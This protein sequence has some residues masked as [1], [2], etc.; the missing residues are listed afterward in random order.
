MG[1]SRDY[2]CLDCNVNFQITVEPDKPE[3]TI[4][5]LYPDAAEAINKGLDE[6]PFCGGVLEEGI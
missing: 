2:E 5:E 3:E 1:I 4:R 6:C